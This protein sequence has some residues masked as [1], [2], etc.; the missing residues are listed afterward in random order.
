MSPFGNEGF[1]SS[2]QS[3]IFTAKL[4]V[5]ERGQNLGT[6]LHQGLRAEAL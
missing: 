4:F 2:S 3:T 1:I 5:L 6:M